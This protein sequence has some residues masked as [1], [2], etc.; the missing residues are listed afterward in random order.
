MPTVL[1][2]ED[3]L[4]HLRILRLT[5]EREQIAVLAATNGQQGIELAREQRPDLI[6]LDIAMPVLDGFEVCEQLKADEATKAIPIVFLTAIT[7][8][9]DA[10]HAMEAGAAAFIPKP[11]EPDHVAQVIKEHLPSA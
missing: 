11:F 3:N 9:E 4:D 5:L 2:V 8:Q 6:L 7:G 1:I 10:R